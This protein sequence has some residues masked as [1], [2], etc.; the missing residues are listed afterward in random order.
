MSCNVLEVS[1]TTLTNNSNEGFTC[2]VLGLLLD[3][4]W[5]DGH[6]GHLFKLYMYI[7]ILTYVY[8]KKVLGS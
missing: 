7:Y 4:L 5:L 2:L 6:L 8:F 1:W 3:G